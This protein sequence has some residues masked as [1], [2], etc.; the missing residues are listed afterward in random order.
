MATAKKETGDLV[1][2]GQGNNHPL[3]AV[4]VEIDQQ[5]AL[6]PIVQVVYQPFAANP[7]VRNNGGVQ[8]CYPVGDG[9]LQ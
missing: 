7:P 3:Q 9:L 2:A 8:C 4:A 1:Q 6:P 5:P